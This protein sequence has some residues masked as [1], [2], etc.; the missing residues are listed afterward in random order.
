M[1]SWYKG[2]KLT[3]WLR[4]GC[5]ASWDDAETHVPGNRESGKGQFR[6]RLKRLADFGVLR[7]PDHMNS[8]GDGI[9]V[10]KANCGLRAYGWRCNHD[11]RSAFVISHVT[12]KARQKADPADLKRARDDHKAYEAERHKVGSKQ[13]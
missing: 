3:I 7:V 11:G 9:F 1:E 12:L 8:E 13:L 2:S 4:F 5:Q 10:V 6:A